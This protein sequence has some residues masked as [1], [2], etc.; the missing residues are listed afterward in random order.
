MNCSVPVSVFQVGSHVDNLRGLIRG[1]FAPENVL[2]FA[3]INEPSASHVHTSNYFV[4]S[5][6]VLRSF[7]F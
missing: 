2:I 6:P 7:T 5:C 3:R 1:E 4:M